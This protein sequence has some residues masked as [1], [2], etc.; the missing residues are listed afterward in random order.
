MSPWSWIA[1]FAACQG[2]LAQVS[3][4]TKAQRPAPEPGLGRWLTD[5]RNAV[6][7]VL[8][9]A[10]IVGGGRKLIQARQARKLGER[11]RSDDLKAD[12]IAPA[13]EYGRDLLPD[14]F[15][16]LD[17]QTGAELR[18]AAGSALAGLWARDQLIAEEEK[19]IVTRGYSVSWQARRRYPRAMD[20]PIP[21]QVQFGV[22]FLGL[23]PGA[24]AP[25]NLEWSTRIRGSG[26]ASLERWGP[27]IAGA[28]QAG[29]T[30]IAA[31][32]PTNGP[33]RLSLE[34]RVRTVG[35]TSSWELDLPA[36]PFS[37]EFDPRLEPAAL[38]APED[39]ARQSEVE[40][41]LA[42]DTMPAAARSGAGE[43]PPFVLNDA[44][45]VLEAPALYA[46]HLPVDLAHRVAIEFD[47]IPG[48]FEASPIVACRSIADGSQA[49]TGARPPVPLQLRGMVPTEQLDRPGEI[50]LRAHLTVDPGLGWTHPA[51][52]SVWPGSIT[53]RWMT[54][55]VVRR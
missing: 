9:T 14:L 24:V 51:I 37:F 43:L 23:Q 35:L 45:A 3:P 40:A 8:L 26:R 50:R 20:A 38:L 29:F 5:S 47:G 21:V 32:F 48:R 22:P 11:L 54:A 33:H 42:L 18:T 31:D 30:L 16:L 7:A 55:R 1:H 17:P 28:T 53:T 41:A 15:A 12:E 49:E 2:W 52:R 36:I 10:L 39:S 27:W 4:G 6:F 44:L 25:G 13:V 46:E 34:A 19:G